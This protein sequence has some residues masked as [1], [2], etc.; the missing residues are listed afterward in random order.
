[1]EKLL[2]EDLKTSM[3]EKN[4]IKKDLLQLVIS[5]AKGFAKDEMR[6]VSNQDFLRSIK[7]EIKQTNDAFE[8]M[9]SFLSEDKQ[10]EYSLKLEILKSYLP[11]QLDESQIMIEVE[12]AFVSLNLE[13]STKSMGTVMKVL[14]EKL[15]ESVDSA[16]LSRCVKD[17]INK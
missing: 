7:S 12:T 13:K 2:M 11:S 15:G 9:K 8:Q 3:K 5:K 10:G 16:V 17:F 4:K 6:E 14:K 1:M